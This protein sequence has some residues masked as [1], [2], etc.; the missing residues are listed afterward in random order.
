M[1]FLDTADGK[2]AEPTEHELQQPKPGAIPLPSPFSRSSP[3]SFPPSS[4]S[5]KAVLRIL[6]TSSI[7]FVSFNH[8]LIHFMP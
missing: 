1:A 7:S 5:V 2:P 4:S 6:F 3:P 8:Q